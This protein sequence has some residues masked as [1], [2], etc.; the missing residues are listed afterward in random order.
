MVWSEGSAWRAR[1]RVFDKESNSATSAKFRFGVT[2]ERYKGVGD[3][4]KEQNFCSADY[5][6]FVSGN[7]DG[8]ICQV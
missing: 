1:S 8:N 6:W 4:L 5:V 2:R 3:V 7:L